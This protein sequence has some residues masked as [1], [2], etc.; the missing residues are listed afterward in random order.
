MEKEKKKKVQLVHFRVFFLPC[1]ALP[2]FALRGASHGRWSSYVRSARTRAREPRGAHPFAS[3]AAAEDARRAEDAG[4]EPVHSGAS[5]ATAAASR[6]S[7]RSSSGG[8]RANEVKDARRRSL[9]ASIGSATVQDLEKIAL[10]DFKHKN[11]TIEHW[12]RVCR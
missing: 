1:F 2:C 3:R 12:E 9:G 5:A 10:S 6:S 11:K 8:T 4:Q 7:S